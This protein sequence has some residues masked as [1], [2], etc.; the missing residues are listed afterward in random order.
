MLLNHKCPV[1]KKLHEKNCVPSLDESY[2][3]ICPDCEKEG[4]IYNKES[5]YM[6]HVFMDGRDE[7][8]TDLKKAVNIAREWAR[9]TGSVRIYKETE[10]S[11]WEGLFMNEDCILSHGKF[12]M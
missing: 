3:L 9:E 5:D 7:W 11:Y 4:Y 12:P 1:C 8:L 6:Y 2:N 10:W